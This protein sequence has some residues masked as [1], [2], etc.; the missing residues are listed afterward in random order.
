MEMLGGPAWGE[1]RRVTKATNMWK[2]GGTLW[3]RVQGS[4][5]VQNQTPIMFLLGLP[6]N[7]SSSPHLPFPLSPTFL[8]LSL[9]IGGIEDLRN[10]RPRNSALIGP[11]FGKCKATYMLA[12]RHT[13]RL[14]STAHN[15]INNPGLTLSQ[16]V[17]D[18]HSRSGLDPSADSR[19]STVYYYR[20]HG[21]L[22]LAIVRCRMR[23]RERW[24]TDRM[25]GAQHR[26]CVIYTAAQNY[27]FS[28]RVFSVDILVM[29]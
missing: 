5:K 22:T 2:R 23:D 29:L 4:W 8:S 27:L 11:P 6:P 17:A 16:R 14:N 7:H 3:G 20:G 13:P 26:R 24:T 19:Q 1:T 18:V 25:Q 12:Y 21:R 10:C 9:S 28:C 15:A